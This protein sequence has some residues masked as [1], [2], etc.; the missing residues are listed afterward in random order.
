MKWGAKKPLNFTDFRLT[1]A[2]KELIGCPSHELS[3]RVPGSKEEGSV[4]G[5][6]CAS[7]M[8]NH[9]DLRFC[10]PKPRSIHSPERFRLL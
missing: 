1:G 8:V 7:D 2:L 6:I 9:R 5:I 4:P 10:A 3:T